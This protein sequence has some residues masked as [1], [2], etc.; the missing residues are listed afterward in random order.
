ML[1]LDSA[2]VERLTQIPKGKCTFRV[3]LEKKNKR[4]VLANKRVQIVTSFFSQH[5]K[6]T[7]LYFWKETI[8]PLTHKLPKELSKDSKNYCR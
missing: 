4:S 2:V 3:S 7:A 6:L 1:P 5:A 8:G